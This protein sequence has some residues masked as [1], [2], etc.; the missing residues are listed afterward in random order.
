MPTLPTV[1]KGKRPEMELGIPKPKI[2]AKILRE[3]KGL[4]A[5]SPINEAAMLDEAARMMAKSTSKDA[6]FR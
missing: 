6:V 3:I 1:H 4:P 2:S 5:G